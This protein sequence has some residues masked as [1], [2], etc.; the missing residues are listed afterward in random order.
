VLIKKSAYL[1]IF[2]KRDSRSHSVYAVA[3]LSV[4]CL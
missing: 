4:C 1:Y 3:Y 2:T